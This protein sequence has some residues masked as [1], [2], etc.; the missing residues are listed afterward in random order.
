MSA[1]EDTKAA[2]GST[3]E[4]AA[5]ANGTVNENQNQNENESKEENNDATEQ[6]LQFKN[7]SD[8]DLVIESDSDDENEQIVNLTKQDF[9]EIPLNIAKSRGKQ[10]TTLILTNNKLQFSVVCYF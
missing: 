9:T 10:A 7:A 3:N 4:T 5:E 2:N 1:E 8:E 6:K